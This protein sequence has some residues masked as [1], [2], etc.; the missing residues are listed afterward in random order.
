MSGDNPYLPAMGLVP[1]SLL[2]TSRLSGSSAA[3]GPSS[4]TAH[5]LQFHPSMY[6][7]PAGSPARSAAAAAPPTRS[8]QFSEAHTSTAVPAATAAADEEPQPE[9][10]TV[11]P[12]M[13]GMVGP[14]AAPLSDM[15]ERTVAQILDLDIDS[16]SVKI[17]KHHCAT[18]KAVLDHFMET[19]SRMLAAQVSAIGDERRKCGAHMDVK[20]QEIEMLSSEL[21]Q[22]A[23]RIADQAE[24][25]NRM[26]IALDTEKHRKRTLALKQRVFHGW[27]EFV[28]VSR[29]ALVRMGKA[30]HHHEV[31]ILQRAAL[32]GWF[33]VAMKQSRITLR[34]KY[35][36]DLGA[37][38]DDMAAAYQGRLAD[39][40]CALAA[41]R[42][43]LLREQDARAAL[44]E[45][46]KQAFMRGVCAL[47]IEAMSVMKRGAPPGGANPAP[48]SLP[49]TAAPPQPGPPP[50]GAPAATSERG[51]AATGV[52][53]TYYTQQRPTVTV[54]R[55][56]GGGGGGEQVPRPRTGGAP[57]PSVVRNA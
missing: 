40:A 42:A 7:G 37:A 44:E 56:P 19:K 33:R 3:A 15:S 17:D 52:A 9:V 23:K 38:N 46:M 49:R 27:G 51:A 12:D 31:E 34:N 18:K 32:R 35:A 48:L 30:V 14:G 10:F 25:I 55:G 24:Y 13:S 6:S 2:F 41:A 43:A 4:G 53:A 45:D 57:M 8:P 21:R 36:A 11:A 39:S 16:L 50:S 29:R 1:G 20:Q 22:G 5:E 28:F 54:T 26:A 47:N